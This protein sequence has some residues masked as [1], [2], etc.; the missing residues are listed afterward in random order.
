MAPSPGPEERLGFLRN[1]LVDGD[2]DQ[3]KR[4]HRSKQRAILISIILQI[5]VVAVLVLLPLLTKG[6]NIAGRVIF[7]PTVP[8]SPSRSPN[9]PT[10]PTHPARNHAAVCRFC[11]PTSIPP[12][13]VLHDPTPAAEPGEDGPPGIPGVPPGDGVI[14]GLTP[15]NGHHE[16]PP[17]DTHNPPTITRRRIS[18]PVQAAMLYH[19][20]EPIYPLLAIQTRR[21][22]RVE[23]HAVISADGS[24]QSLEV[25][26]G[27]P[28]FIR[29]ALTAVRE[30]RYHPTILNGQPVEVDTHI[31]VIYTLSH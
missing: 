6:E 7:Y 5:L 4:V 12:A 15:P 26:S 11:V 24:I 19:R 3:E 10:N 22:G 20:V 8:Y 13:I 16:P 21:E 29:S 17:P 2:S 27:D 14:G 28:L 31:T 1:C 25:I 18:E 30:W 23:L 9:H